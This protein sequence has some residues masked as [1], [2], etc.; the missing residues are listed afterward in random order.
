MSKHALISI[1]ICVLSIVFLVSENS[2]FG[3][4]TA[5]QIETFADGTLDTWLGGGGATHAGA[6]TIITDGG[7]AGSG[8]G[9]QYL[10]VTSGSGTLGPRLLAISSVPSTRWTGDFT[11]INAVSAD[12]LNPNTFPITMRLAIR[13]NTTMTEPAWVTT[14]AAATTLQPGSGWTH[15]VFQLNSTDM[16]LTSGSKPFASVL[17]AVQELRF[18]DSA[19]ASYMG[20]AFPNV[21]H[22]TG[23][24]GVDNITAVPEPGAL[25]L[26][27]IAL[28]GLSFLARRGEFLSRCHLTHPKT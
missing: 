10:Q 18:V 28:L 3:H 25:I 22:T 21:D 9:D 23:S 2:A 8:T 17:S 13:A 5:G 1:L 6:Q 12:I 7:P 15:I 19:T 14:D 26:A 4:P 27:T 16:T 11:G 24:F 20:D